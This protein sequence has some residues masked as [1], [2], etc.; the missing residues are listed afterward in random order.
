MSDWS[1]DVCSSDL[2]VV[3]GGEDEELR[4]DAA[5]LERGESRK[6]LAVGDTEILLAGDDQHRGLT[7]RDMIDRA[8]FFGVGAFPPRAAIIPFVEPQ[9]LGL[10]RHRAQEIGRA[11]GREIVC[12]YV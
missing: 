4:G 9:L 12:Q 6:T 1:S 8:P 3:L 5:A 11:S 2:P 7:F 10:D